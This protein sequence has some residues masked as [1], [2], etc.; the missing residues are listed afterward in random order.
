MAAVRSVSWLSYKYC[1]RH[2]A[3]NLRSVSRV[4]KHWEMRPTDR[5]EYWST[6][7]LLLKVLILHHPIY[8]LHAFVAHKDP[9]GHFHISLLAAAALALFQVCQPASALS[10]LVVYAS[11]V[12]LVFPFLWLILCM[13]CIIWRQILYACLTNVHK[14]YPILVKGQS[15]SCVFSK[16]VRTPLH[17]SAHADERS[18]AV[19]SRDQCQT[20]LA[21]LKQHESQLQGQMTALQS[22]ITTLRQAKQQVLEQS[23]ARLTSTWTQTSW[24]SFPG[25]VWN[26]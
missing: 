17:V 9:T 14:N 19:Q 21:D 5:Y 10:V 2:V 25:L 20:L 24:T 4:W 7:S 18:G 16:I 26:C 22:E 12:S 1:M 13:N 6:N 8:L 3:T 15:Y 11:T 23:N